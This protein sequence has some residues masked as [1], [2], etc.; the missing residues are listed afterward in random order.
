MGTAVVLVWGPPQHGLYSNQ[1]A[2]ITSDCDAM[3]FHDHQMALITS[4]CDALQT[5]NKI[6]SSAV[7]TEIVSHITG[8]T[9]H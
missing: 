8:S 4:D 7:W 1:M 3:R 9:S 2:L 6:S 5:G